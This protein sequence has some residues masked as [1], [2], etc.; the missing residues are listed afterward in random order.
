M[1]SHVL[2][3]NEIVPQSY[4]VIIAASELEIDA[5]FR[6]TELICSESNVNADATKLEKDSGS[7]SGVE[8]VIRSLGA[9]FNDS[10][11]HES[12]S[13][14]ESRLEEL[15]FAVCFAQERIAEKC[16]WPFHEENF[17]REFTRYI[18]RTH[19]DFR[20][21]LEKYDHEDLTECEVI[22]EIESALDEVETELSKEDRLGIWICGLKYGVSDCRLSAVL[23]GLYQLGFEGLWQEGSRPHLAM[24]ATQA[25]QRPSVQ[26]ATKWSE[27]QDKLT[28][29]AQE[30]DELRSARMALYATVG[31]AGL[32]ILRK[33]F[34]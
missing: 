9:E 6:R 13:L 32:Y 20:H 23:T 16:R 26:K 33:V 24:Y 3:Y 25:F 18:M 34:K 5:E 19:S 22:K 11:V 28:L 31:L 12:L 17:R 1:G 29:F 27:N 4:A 10:K 2:Y 14:L 8:N 21:W 30:S 7:I 15:T